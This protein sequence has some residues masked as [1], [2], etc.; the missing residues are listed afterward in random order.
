MKHGSQFLT[1]HF[2]APTLK[3]FAN[4][5]VI[6]ELFEVPPTCQNRGIECILRRPQPHHRR[7]DIE[8][9][10]DVQ[11]LNEYNPRT[12]LYQIR[13]GLFDSKEAASTFQSTIRRE[14][15]GEYSDSWIVQVTR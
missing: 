1:G 10:F 15:P 5:G 12:G 11:V 8:Q 2:L 3:Q 4:S 9:R 7:E 13:V 6:E 14:H